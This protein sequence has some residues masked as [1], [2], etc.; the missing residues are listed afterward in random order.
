MLKV[1]EVIDD[2]LT[3][4]EHLRCLRLRHH[5]QCLFNGNLTDAC[6]PVAQSRTRHITAKQR[7]C[8]R[9]VDVLRVR[10]G[11]SDVLGGNP[12][13]VA[14]RYGSTVVTPAWARHT[15]RAEYLIFG[16]TILWTK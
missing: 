10:T 1:G 15:V 7:G 4:F 8:R 14:Y 3:H 2:N 13:R 5:S 12:D 6:A 11:L 16:E 9:I